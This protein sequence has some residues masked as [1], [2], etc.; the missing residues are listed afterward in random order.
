MLY[1]PVFVIL[2]NYVQASPI[3]T[4]E[5]MPLNV[6]Q[7]LPPK[8]CLLPPNFGTQGSMAFLKNCDMADSFDYLP[9]PAEFSDVYG[10]HPKI[11]CPPKKISKRKVCFPTDAWCPIYQ[12][13]FKTNIDPP[14]WPTMANEN[15]AAANTS[16][17]PMTQCPALMNSPVTPLTVAPCS[18][19]EDATILKICCPNDQVQEAVSTVQPPRFP[20]DGSARPCED[21]HSMCSTWASNGAC[22]LDR[23]HQISDF[24]NNGFV[25]SDVMFN[26]M[27]TACQQSCGW[28]RDRGCVDDH[29][30]CV[31][32]S[33]QGMC[34]ASPFFMG[35]LCR[36]SCGVCGFLSTDSK[37]NQQI[38]GKSYTDISKEDFE[39]GK[40]AELKLLKP[41]SPTSSDTPSGDSASEGDIYCTATIVAD[42]WMVSASHCFDDFE[43]SRN[44]LRTEII[45]DQTEN[46]EFIEVRRVFKH[47]FYVFPKLYHD[48]AVV[49]LGRRIEY[50]FDKF[51]DTPACL[52]QG[53]N[54]PDFWFKRTGTVQGYGVTEN[55]DQAGTILTAD[56]SIIGHR[57]C[58]QMLKN[59]STPNQKKVDLA[60]PQG[61]DSEFLCTE[62]TCEEKIINNRTYT[63]CKGTCKGDSGGPLYSNDEKQRQ[64]LV[65]VTSG[66]IGCG[67][68]LPKWYTRVEVFSG[69]VKCIMDTSKV[70]DT[71]EDIEKACSEN[72]YGAYSNCLT[73]EEGFKSLDETE[74]F[75]REKHLGLKKFKIESDDFDLRGDI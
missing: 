14:E 44:K 66:G 70:K 36:E 52:D 38:D 19:D 53:Q 17:V 51:G 49:E 55:G 54:P 12:R 4:P 69:W 73:E 24:D 9:L 60:L 18:F 67:T 59:T 48:I 2:L 47:P 37:E 64:T 61:F 30:G 34:I 58:E 45:R 26:F 7:G 72:Y 68:D 1:L 3:I 15:C 57:E 63:V 43:K 13:K 40:L 41:S 16:C 50:N 35:L 46:K 33:K 5:N 74:K 27:Q 75:C 42:K 22:K 6:L 23:H 8:F 62:G 71:Q 25:K 29:P 39:C 28:C 32:W 56:V 11:C 21:K 65:G 10:I 20:V 31:G